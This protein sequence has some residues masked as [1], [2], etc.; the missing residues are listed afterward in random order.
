MKCLI[1][2]DVGLYPWVDS[3]PVLAVP[4]ICTTMAATVGEAGHL[5]G[6]MNLDRGGWELG[7]GG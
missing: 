1:R 4:L 3:V 5:L 6:G 7:V 2:E